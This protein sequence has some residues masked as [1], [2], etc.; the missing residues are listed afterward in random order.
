MEE[1]EKKL[2]IK[3]VLITVFIVVL[4]FII[5]FVS[6]IITMNS[7]R[8]KEPKVVATGDNKKLET[9]EEKKQTDENT[10]SENTQNKNTGNKNTENKNSKSEKNDKKINFVEDMIKNK[11]EENKTSNEKET[12]NNTGKLPVYNENCVQ[13]IKD[14][15]YSDEKN[16]Y[17]TFDDG[18]SP[19]VTPQILKILKEEQ[20]PAT[21]FVLGSRVE[22]YPDLLKQEFNEGHYI[23]NHGYSHSYSSIY[24]SVDTVVYEYNRTEKAIQNALRNS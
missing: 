8:K 16:I 10:E 24:Q 17:L 11:Q 7:T 21:F 22:L 20:V 9:H 19:N 5:I 23:A 6:A 13:L 12:S 2:N 3:K 18:P 1:N 14:I 4:A 15:Y